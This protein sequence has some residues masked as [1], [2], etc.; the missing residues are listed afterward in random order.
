MH[1]ASTLRTFPLCQAIFHQHQPLVSMHLSSF[2]MPI[3]AQIIMTF[4]YPTGP[5]VT[6][7]LSQGYKVNRLKLIV[8]PTH[9][10]NSRQAH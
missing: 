8:R 1:L 4:Y 2:A 10:R 3:V 5:L 6:R 7:L 9:L